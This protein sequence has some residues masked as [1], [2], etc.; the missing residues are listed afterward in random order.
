MQFDDEVMTISFWLAPENAEARTELA[1]RNPELGQWL[2]MIE[3]KVQEELKKLEGQ[4]EAA[5]VAEK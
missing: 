1:E 4:G 5:K 2:S 3:Q